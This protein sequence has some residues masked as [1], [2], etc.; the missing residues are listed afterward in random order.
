ME[1]Q[2]VTHKGKSYNKQLIFQWKFYRPEGNGRLYLQYR[3]TNKQ[4]KSTDKI[5][6]HGK[7]LI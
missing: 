7:D 1:K 5:T 3:K 6:I 4:T 2:Q